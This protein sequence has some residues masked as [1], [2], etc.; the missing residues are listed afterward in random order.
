MTKFYQPLDLTVN[1]HA[2]RFL[3]NKFSTW[4]GN[5]ISKQLDEGVKIDSV[6]VKL[7]LTTLKPPHTQWVV[8]FYNEMTSSKG[9][10]HHRERLESGRNYRRN[11]PL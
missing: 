7:Q 11:S 2:K 1:G 3:K 6:N 5:Q 9:K 8:D 10:K 4:Y